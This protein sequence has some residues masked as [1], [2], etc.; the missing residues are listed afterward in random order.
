MPCPA[1]RSSRCSDPSGTNSRQRTAIGP[2]RDCTWRVQLTAVRLCRGVP[3]IFRASC[4]EEKDQWVETLR[5]LIKFPS[6][7]HLAPLSYFGKVRRE[8]YEAYSGPTTQV[9]G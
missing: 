9:R 1:A 5:R 4:D 6:A 8:V 3:L 7:S 2:R